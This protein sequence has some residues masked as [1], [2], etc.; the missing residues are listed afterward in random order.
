MDIEDRINRLLSHIAKTNKLTEAA[1]KQVGDY[2]NVN[3]NLHRIVYLSG[4][5]RVDDKSYFLIDIDKKEL[6]SIC[7]ELSSKNPMIVAPEDVDRRLSEFIWELKNNIWTIRKI[8]QKIKEITYSITAYKGEKASVMMPVWG[9]ILRSPSLSIGEVQFIP[10]PF[11]REL[12]DKIKRI[13]PNG[14]GNIVIANTPSIGDQATIF[15]NAKTKINTAINVIRA[16]S[17]PF[18]SNENVFQQISIEGDFRPLQSFSLINYSGDGKLSKRVETFNGLGTGGIVPLDL[19]RYMSI[20]D[21]F[22]FSEFLKIISNPTKFGKRLIKAA[23]WL[24]EATKPDVLSGKFVK[25][26]FSIDAMIGAEE[27][28]IPDNGKR[29]RIAE[30]SAFL[31]GHNYKDRK[32]IWDSMNKIIQRRDEIA[33]GSSDANITEVDVEEAGKWARK[34]LS[35]LLLRAPKFKDIPQ[36]AEWVKRQSLLG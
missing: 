11:S 26:A 34:L 36:L 25:I 13:D 16:F 12:D 19:N 28:G 33:H 6:N 27:K 31:I 35:E 18:N 24:G 2:L 32:T 30:R 15:I 1:G 4:S 9:L 5:G 10:P 8:K 20:M 21:I 23:D 22:G 29:A 7:I 14:V 3:K 17:F